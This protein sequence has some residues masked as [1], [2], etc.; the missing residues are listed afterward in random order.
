MKVAECSKEFGGQ[1]GTEQDN[2]AEK[3][4]HDCQASVGRRG[5]P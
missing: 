3:D 5:L 2:G 1:T 4:I